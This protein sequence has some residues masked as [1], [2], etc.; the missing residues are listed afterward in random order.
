M[1]CLELKKVGNL[2]KKLE[3]ILYMDGKR[4][5][6]QKRVKKMGLLRILCELEKE[7]ENKNFVCFVN[8]KAN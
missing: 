8:L 7:N 6:V 4:F 3:F 2:C 1:G 5:W